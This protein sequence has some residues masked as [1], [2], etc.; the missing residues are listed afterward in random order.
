MTSKEYSIINFMKEIKDKFQENILALI[1]ESKHLKDEIQIKCRQLSINA[2]KLSME[3]T[4]R[5]EIEKEHSTSFF[6]IIT[7]I[8][9]YLETGN[10]DLLN[11]CRKK[12]MHLNLRLSS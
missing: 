3:D 4:Y 8:N 5:L 2:K 12:N 9:R 10:S 7:E 1:H 11:I 6:E